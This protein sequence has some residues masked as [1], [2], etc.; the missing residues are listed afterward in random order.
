MIIL[1]IN[2]IPDFYL[3][4]GYIYLQIKTIAA[5]KPIIVL[6]KITVLEKTDRRK[7]IRPQGQFHLDTIL[8]YDNEKKALIGE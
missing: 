5:L 3:W 4:R 1:D 8:G 6:V 2:L 7:F